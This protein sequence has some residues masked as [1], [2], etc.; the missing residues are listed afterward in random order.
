MFTAGVAL[1]P[2]TAVVRDSRSRIVRDLERHD[3]QVLENSQPRQI[4]EFRSTD[5]GPVS[6]AFVFDTSGSMHGRKLERAKDVVTRLL[7]Q[8]DETADEAALFTFDKEVSQQTPFSSDFSSI[9]QALDR[10]PAWGLTSMYDGIAMAAER[11]GTRQRQRRAVVVVTDCLDTSSD[12]TLH[13]VYAV[14][15]AIEVPVYIMAVDPPTDSSSRTA[16]RASA[17]LADLAFETGGDLKYV[18][19]PENADRTI[20]AMMTELRQQYFIA[21]EAAQASG[22]HRLD[23]TTRRKDTTVRARGGYLVASRTPRNSD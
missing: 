10:A 1:V 21:I 11:V 16:T 19:T 20:A 4:V 2:I 15:S 23:V 13:D 14:A 17:G 8:M 22:W 6:L 5:H 7:Q 12:R 9:R 3:F 18:T